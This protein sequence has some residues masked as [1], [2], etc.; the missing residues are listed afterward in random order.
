M[1]SRLVLGTLVAMLITLV[2]LSADAAVS[3]WCAGKRA[4]IVGTDGPDW[5]EGTPG[6][7]VISLGGG[8]DTA[9]PDEGDIVCLGDGNDIA[10]T[11]GRTTVYGGGGHDQVQAKGTAT[12]FKGGPGD[13]Q[14]RRIGAS[15]PDKIYGGSGN[16]RLYVSDLTSVINVGTGLNA[17]NVEDNHTN[18]FV[19]NL[20]KPSWT[21]GGV[22]KSLGGI[23]T[24]IRVTGAT[25]DTVIGAPR[26]EAVT[27]GPGDTVR[28]GDGSDSLF[29]V[30]N[31]ASQAAYTVD[32]GPGA[33]LFTATTGMSGT[34][35][36]GTGN[37]TAQVNAG[38]AGTVYG[39]SGDDVFSVNGWTPSG[40]IFPALDG[41]TGTDGV[42]LFLSQG[43]TVDLLAGT[44]TT[45]A[46]TFAAI[47]FENADG[48]AYADI[49]Y[50]TEGANRL[51]GSNGEDKVYGRGGNDY[52]DGGPG[53]NWADGGPGV[54]T[55]G[56]FSVTVNCE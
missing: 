48:S 9:F 7:D 45:G 20:G 18:P 33:D 27:F 19:F 25:A 8:D 34:A 15:A 38:S 55:C 52:L 5:S 39:D 36:L 41:G 1:R 43:T 10:F 40:D 14:F 21:R 4:T 11:N 29:P 50:G 31:S 46:G 17:V 37:D 16:D 13:D 26:S 28:S 32:A 3:R 54:D 44:F 56:G 30:S 51:T 23:V 2:P 49:I 6:K 22:T 47:G 53:A 35:R 42:K 12:T 24:G